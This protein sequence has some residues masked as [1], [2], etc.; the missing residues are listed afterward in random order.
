MAEHD[1][2]Q[3]QKANAQVNDDAM[4]CDHVA[5]RLETVY[6]SMVS[7]YELS[8]RLIGDGIS[9]RESHLVVAIRDLARA[10]AHDLE[11]CTEK[12]SGEQLG[13]FAEHFGA[14]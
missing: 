4:N 12:L 1:S 9:E 8:Q 14:I 11:K 2:T 3:A 7:M 10:A 5:A 13:Y 6:H